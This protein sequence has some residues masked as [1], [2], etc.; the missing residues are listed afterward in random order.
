MLRLDW[1]IFG[2]GHG[3]RSPFCDD[4]FYWLSGEF[5][6][7]MAGH[8]AQLHSVQWTHP[9]AGEERVI[10][11]LRFR[12]LHSYRKWGRVM[13]ARACQDL[14]SDIDGANYGLRQM[15]RMIG[16]SLPMDR[17]HLYPPAIEQLS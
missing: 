13:I 12:P 15:E 3:F 4:R 11:G 7:F 9:N 14:P 5:Y 16:S 6:T 10:A 17:S 2:N 8:G 1:R